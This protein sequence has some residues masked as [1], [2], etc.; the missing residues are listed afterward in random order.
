MSGMKLKPTGGTL[1]E[2]LFVIASSD[3]ADIIARIVLD[4]RRLITPHLEM[5]AFPM[6]FVHDELYELS[7]FSSALRVTVRYEH[8][9]FDFYLPTKN[10]F[11]L[12]YTPESI[13]WQIKD[14]VIF[15]FTQF[16]KREI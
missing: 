15:A 14:S 4:Y 6:I 10:I 9:G 5:D 1:S 3:I 7:E 2:N 11:D 8:R 16:D 13:F 12:V